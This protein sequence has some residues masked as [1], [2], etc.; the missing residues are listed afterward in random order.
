MKRIL[1]NA[2][3]I[4]ADCVVERG[5]LEIDNGV[6]AAVH[7]RP[8][9]APPPLSEDLDGDDLLPGLVEVHTDNLEKHLMPR[10]GVLWPTLPAVVTHDA[11]CVAAGITTVLDALSV[12][13]LEGDSVR[14]DT[15]QSAFEAIDAGMRRRVF[16][17]EH[18][19]HLRCELAYPTL[20]DALSPLIGHPAVRL[21]SLMDHTPGQR[22]YRD[23]A[24]YKKY[25]A[26]KNVSWNDDTFLAA[27]EQRKLKQR[28]Y[29]GRHRQAVVELARARGVAL[30]SHD[31]TELSHIDEAVR[32]GVAMSEFPT[33]LTAAR[34]AREQGLMTVMGAP[35][36]VRG[37]SHSGNVAALELAGHGLLDILSSDYV[38]ASLLHAAYLLGRQ[39]G[40][41]LSRAVATVTLNPARAV[42][43]ADRGAVAVGQRADLIQARERD[44][45]PL[46]RQ[47]WSAGQRVF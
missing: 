32:D 3:L 22:Q 45:I 47:V 20:L 5:A 43:L 36:I 37:G 39:P 7:P 18:L 11:Q 40:W 12:G 27:V 21:V 15:L 28:Q 1:N 29:A 14:L 23:L 42:G 41:D 25:Y 34:A 6:I 30:A 8:L 2:R 44:G 17:A 31:D 19:F 35:N 4:L 33:T 9:S 10:N 38:P 24:Q 46:V 13:D 16:R 26:K